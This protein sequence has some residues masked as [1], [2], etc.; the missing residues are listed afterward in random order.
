MI[1]RAP[2]SVASCPRTQVVDGVS[3]HGFLHHV[4]KGKHLCKEGG[5]NETIFNL[6][7]FRIRGWRGSRSLPGLTADPRAE[8]SQLL[9][10]S[11]CGRLAGPCAPSL[12]THTAGAQSRFVPEDFTE[13]FQH[14][15]KDVLW[16]MW[17]PG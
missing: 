11:S 15:Q 17:S 6:S 16:A 2:G 9:L 14:E 1:V 7:F 8:R 13:R 5:D 4:G 3:L 12:V 10:V